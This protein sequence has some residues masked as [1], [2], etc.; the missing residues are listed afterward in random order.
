M[1]QGQAATCM[2]LGS[3]GVAAHVFAPR[4]FAGILAEMRPG[5][6]VMLTNL[7]PSQPGDIAFRLVRAGAVLAVGFP[8]IDPLHFKARMKVVPSSRLVGMDNAASGDATT[9][10]RDG[11]GLMLHDCRHGRAAALAHH[12]DATAL[13]VLVLAST[14]IDASEPMIFWPDVAA[15]PPA[16]D[17]NDP[18]Q[19][20]R[21]EVRRQSASQLVQQ[22]ERGLR[23]QPEIA[24]Q[25]TTANALG[26]VDEQAESHEQR[27]NR[28]LSARE[29][30]PAGRRELPLAGLAFEQPA[31]SIS[32][33]DRAAAMGTDR[34]A[35]GVGPPHPAEHPVC[36]V[37]RQI[38][39]I[40][41]R[42]RPCRRGHEKMLR[43]GSRPGKGS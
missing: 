26:G 37:F 1:A 27:P 25:L 21:R 4:H 8:M 43:H 23:V 15:K 3:G 35:V 6:M 24:A 41:Q 18:A 9:N 32:I 30:G 17:F 7:R 5:D 39:K 31:T 12:H 36:C 22:D 38:A 34:G 11:L 42:Q 20:G 10:D 14:P 19:T 33:D 29:R 40:D 16:I 2:E 13:A 28:Q